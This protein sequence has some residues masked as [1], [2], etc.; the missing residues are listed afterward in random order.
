MNRYW[1]LPISFL[2]I[3]FLLVSCNATATNIRTL[4]T[5]TTN[6]A[7]DDSQVRA[8]TSVTNT[9]AIRGSHLPVVDDEIRENPT[10]TPLPDIYLMTTIPTPLADSQYRLAD[11]TADK[12]NQLIIHLEY[13]PETLTVQQSGY[14]GCVYYS[15][16]GYAAFSQAEAL[17]RFPDSLFS[18][19]WKWDFAYNTLRGK[20]SS[21]ND[22]GWIYSGYL[23]EALNQAE[24][25][26]AQVKEEFER[27]DTRLQVEVFPVARIAGNQFNQI[28]SIMPSSGDIRGAAYIWLVQQ[29]DHYRAYPL[30]SM[31]DFYLVDEW[32]EIKLLDLT[33]DLIPEAIVRH[34]DLGTGWMHTGYL[35]V[36][37]LSQGVPVRLSFDHRS[38]NFEI[39]EW[40]GTN[41]APQSKE[42][43]LGVPLVMYGV[44]C[45]EFES[46]WHYR[47]N[48]AGF[49]LVRIDLPQ[50]SDI[51]M[52]PGCADWL[53]NRLLEYGRQGNM[54]AL[55]TIVRSLDDY[56]YSGNNS[57]TDSSTSFLSVDE[58]RFK[59]GLILGSRGYEDEAR[60]Q[61]ETILENN[62]TASSQWV[63]E[64]EQYYI[65]LTNQTG[66]LD[67]CRFSHPCYPFFSLADLVQWIPSEKFTESLI[68]LSQMG[69]PVNFSGSYNFNHIDG[70][71][72]WI[73]DYTDVGNGHYDLWILSQGVDEISCVL[74]TSVYPLEEIHDAEILLMTSG[75][76]RSFY[77]INTG[78]EEINK[79]IFYTDIDQPPG[80]FSDTELNQ[81]LN[82]LTDKLLCREISAGVLIDEVLQI[83]RI[84]PGRSSVTLAYGVDPARMDYLIGLAYELAGDTES[85]A[86]TYLNLWLTY[87]QSAYAIMAMYKLEQVP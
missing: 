21:N 72:Y 17:S 12:A 83:K 31:M 10:K 28:F 71:Q 46:E 19:E 79:K 13:Y 8:I 50:M 85:A 74:A 26:P 2:M 86:N 11:W 54:I 47:W 59:V 53:I 60:L 20:H 57:E 82:Q 69:V 7:V 84:F 65:S 15:A 80:S 35:D 66:M 6:G 24:I 9:P 33:G 36:F 37:D 45:T 44:S 42:V 67:F 14:L 55:A 63:E 87:P 27:K 49:E 4:N 40:R 62:S 1:V 68:L 18:D 41:D 5:D 58:L 73:L 70:L 30:M 3:I 22:A 81:S 25:L 64:A 34:V 77:Q 29:N 75:S 52:Q 39:A 16:F 23:E 48:N 51:E 38:W 61:M 43:T 32:T 78:S 76:E 56:P